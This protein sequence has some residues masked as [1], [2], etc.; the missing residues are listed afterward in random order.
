MR[1]EKFRSII[2]YNRK[3]QKNV[4][5]KVRDFYKKMNVDYEKD[6]LN[7]TAVY[8]MFFDEMDYLVIEMP[9]KD[10]EIGAISYKLDYFGYTILNSSLPRVNVNFALAHEICHVCSQQILSGKKVELYLNEHYYEYEEEWEANLFAGILLMPTPRFTEMFDRFKKEQGD[11]DTYETIIV[12]LMNHFEVP[13]MAA[14]IRAYELN[15]LPD[16][17]VL[18]KLLSVSGHMVEDEFEKLWFDGRILKPTR[19]DDFS[20]LEKVVKRVGSRCVEDEI[21]DSES[22]VAI[23]DNMKKIYDE[24][25]G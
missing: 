1:F 25:R 12:K 15:L 19:R 10:K 14:V 22:V 3:N 16:G 6:L 8:R 5:D 13:Y 9:F 18:Q 21:L 7:L 23:L 20:R 17:K 2:E 24:I 4:A 11:D